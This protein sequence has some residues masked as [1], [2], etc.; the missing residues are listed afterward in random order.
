MVII[1][2]QHRTEC[3]NI[4]WSRRHYSTVADVAMIYEHVSGGERTH[5]TTSTFVARN[6]VAFTLFHFYYFQRRT[7]NVKPASAC[8]RVSGIYVIA[9]MTP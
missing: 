2:R 6:A 4:L 7:E 5:N 9:C 1:S 3:A 8:R